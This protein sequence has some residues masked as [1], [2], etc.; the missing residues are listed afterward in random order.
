[1][2]HQQPEQP[3][4]ATNNSELDQHVLPLSDSLEFH[5]EPSSLK[6]LANKTL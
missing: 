4:L 5:G 1:M 3:T 6:T 2:N